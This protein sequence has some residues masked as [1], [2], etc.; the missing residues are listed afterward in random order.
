[1]EILIL[2]QMKDLQTGLYIVKSI[3][4]LGHMAGYVDIRAI[5]EKKGLLEAQNDIV[6]QASDLEMNP[7]IVMVLKGLELTLDTLNKLKELYPNAKFVNWFFDVYLSD[8]RIWENEKFDSVIKFYDYFMCSLKGVADK[9]QRF[10]FKNAIHVGEAC[11]PPL[12]GEQYMNN[13]QKR[14]YGSDVA[15]I[16]SVGMVGIH[17]N[18]VEFLKKIAREGFDL[19]GMT[20][21]N[22]GL[23]MTGSHRITAMNR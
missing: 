9:L 2:G 23:A 22:L 3:E 13:F 16:G 18:R 1:M 14:K 17:N 11:Y 4:E 6:K 10:G 21:I 20:D 12:H 7:D 15:F 19:K 5:V 8:K